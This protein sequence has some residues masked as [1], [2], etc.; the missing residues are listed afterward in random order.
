M[1]AKMEDE[2]VDAIGAKD[3]GSRPALP[4]LNVARASLPK[5][6]VAPVERLPPSSLAL[7]TSAAASVIPRTIAS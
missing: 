1:Y 7:L 5:P 3:F 6:V 2:G 4:L